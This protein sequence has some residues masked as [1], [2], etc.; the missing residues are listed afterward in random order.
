MIYISDD[1]LT[2]NPPYP[3][4]HAR[5]GMDN[6][7][8]T[9]EISAT[10]AIDGFPASAVGNA[11]T[12]E[13]WRPVNGTGT[14]TAGFAEQS[15]DYIG[16]AS[17]N[18]AGGSVTVEHSMNGAT[19]TTVRTVSPENNAP[20]MFLFQP[21]QAKYIRVLVAATN[22]SVA[23]IY[24]G[25]TLEMQRAVFGGISP[26]NFGRSTV[27]RPNESESGLWLGRN[28][29]RQGSETSVTW[30][31]LTYDWYKDNFDKFAKDAIKYPFFFAMRP[32]TYPEMTGYMWTQGDIV[33]TLSGIRNYLNVSVPMLGVEVD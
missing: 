26:V 1:F 19:W 18:L 10:S 21:V 20:L 31:N 7:V 14:I 5:I 8:R 29:I 33:P 22:A 4:T 30:Q 12:Y 3:L 23:V 2:Y 28:V 9:A 25:K 6:A 24:A 15:I 27:I 13:Y 32:A 16:I 11:L 17:H